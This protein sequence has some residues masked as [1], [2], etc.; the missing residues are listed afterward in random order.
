MPADNKL[1]LIVE[2]DVN[3]ANAS[4]ESVNTGLSSM[5]QT[6]AN[7]ARGASRG[8]DGLTVSMAKGATAGNLLAESLKQAISWAK[9]WT[10]DAMKMAAHEARM[11][12]STR[13]LAMAHDISAESMER[14]VEQVKQVGFHGEDAL[15][16]IDRM[17]I[18]DLDLSKAQGLAKIAKDA[19]AIEDIS[20]PEALERLMQAIEFGNARALRAVGLRVNFE[21]EI[22]L[23]ELKLGRT[24]SENEAVHLRY[25][26]VMQK[27][28]DI[29]GAHAAAAGT[30]EAQMKALSPEVHELREAVGAQ[31]QEQFRRAVGMFRDLVG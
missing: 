30:A 6:A 18:A 22:K 11:E 25:N 12:V 23:Q 1:E 3:R 26:A 13:A 28:S 15:Y 2:V 7:A 16:T 10:V 29:R 8:I 31:F 5:E 20:A 9:Q 21:K 27:A 17:I 14:A 4:I 24:L 19:A